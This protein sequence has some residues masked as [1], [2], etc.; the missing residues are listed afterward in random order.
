[1]TVRK[2]RRHFYLKLSQG[3]TGFTW[4]QGF[5]RNCDGL[6]LGACQFAS[7]RGFV[8]FGWVRNFFIRV[9]PNLVL[10]YLLTLRR[11]KWI[12]N[13]LKAAS[14]KSPDSEAIGGETLT[15]YA[16]SNNYFCETVK[17][18]VLTRRKIH[19]RIHFDFRAAPNCGQSGPRTKVCYCEELGRAVIIISSVSANCIQ[20]TI[21]LL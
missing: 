13:P 6:P 17:A 20:K 18:F 9:W 14:K 12:R 15:A 19:F 7:P 11:K 1:M 2:A 16:E 8:L 4:S 5:D 10:Q 3:L 21:S